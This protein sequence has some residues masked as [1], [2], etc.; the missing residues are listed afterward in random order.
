VRQ[1]LTYIC[2]LHDKYAFVHAAVPLAAAAAL[3]GDDLWAA[4]ILGV[5]D[6][7][8]ERTGA[9]VVV[10][11]VQQ[12]KAQVERDT[13]SRLGPDQWRRAHAAGRQRS[14][15]SL[16]HDIDGVLSSRSVSPRT[17]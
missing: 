6:I 3:K 16:L 8:A 15:E 4:R 5:R 17:S 7:V 14:I 2:D 13:R 10:K 9:V 12:L 1:S 11:P